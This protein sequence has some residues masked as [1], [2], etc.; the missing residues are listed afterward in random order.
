MV[1]MLNNKT[2]EAKLFSKLSNLETWARLNLYW[3]I[4]TP[5]KCE[6]SITLN[7]GPSSSVLF[8]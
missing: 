7:L 4:L 8:I 5:W 2:F 6:E 3:R 1:D